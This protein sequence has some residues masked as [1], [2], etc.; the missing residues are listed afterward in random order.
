[1]PPDRRYIKAEVR[2]TDSA[3]PK[4]VGHGATFNT[5]SLD[6]GGFFEII[7]PGAFDECLAAGADIVGMWNHDQRHDEGRCRRDRPAL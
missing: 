5:R 4:I 6:L 1:M 3:S 2:T 7:A